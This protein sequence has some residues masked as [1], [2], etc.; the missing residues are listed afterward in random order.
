M[1]GSTTSYVDGAQL[2]E[3]AVLPPHPARRHTVHYG[4]E[5]REQTIGLEV[6]SVGDGPGLGL[7]A[8]LPEMC[9]A[10]KLHEIDWQG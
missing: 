3:E 6:A 2:V 9:C 4:V 1:H 5:E 10:T 8:F 7:K